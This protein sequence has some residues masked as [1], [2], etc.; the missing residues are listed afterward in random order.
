MLRRDRVASGLMI[1]SA[2]AKSERP[3]HHCGKRLADA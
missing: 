3:T 1:S 2:R